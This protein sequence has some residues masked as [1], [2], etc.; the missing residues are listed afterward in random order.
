MPL[1][2]NL[3][4]LGTVLRLARRHLEA[5]RCAWRE[6][7][8]RKPESNIPGGEV[9]F[10][11]AVLE[12]QQAPPS[13]IGRAVLWTIMALFAL[14]AVWACIGK[15]DIVSVARGRIVP[16]GYTKTIQP[17]E[18]GLVTAIHVRNGQRVT[19]GQVLI[20]L[21][22]TISGAD[23][24]RIRQEYDA[25][26]V[27]MARLQALLQ[28][29]A[30]IQPSMDADPAYTALQQ[31]LLKDQMEEYLARIAAAREVVAQRQAAIGAIEADILRL[32]QILPMVTHRAESFRGLYAQGFGSRLEA[33][34]A[35][36]ERIERVQELA[37]SRRRHELEQSAL[38]E[39]RQ[40]LA[41]IG[42]EFRK[43]IQSQLADM[44]NR[45]KALAEE[46]VKATHADRR[47]RLTAPVD[48]TVQQLAV[49]TIGGVVTP[50]QPLMVIVPD[51]DQLEVEAWVENK[52]IGFVAVG[53]AAEIKVDAFP[54]TRY[55]IIDGEL[56][57]LAKDSMLIEEVGYVYTARV[58]MAKAEMQVENGRK[59]RLS[60][61]MDVAV[62]IRTG[63]RRLIEFLLS[64]ILKA[65]RESARER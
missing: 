5:W 54:F 23:R 35:E 43:S 37:A 53:Q 12:M 16:G 11:P 13:P 22:P 26:R 18:S 28:N 64:P 9:E 40:N 56:V 17:L 29:R 59:V 32:E 10:L 55:G 61:G 2:D 34:E 49:H 21:D 36:R 57:T 8:R 31:R 48:G 3:L 20:D 42:S 7:S 24:A 50:A 38:V 25:A 63:Q 6:E 44:E 33:D 62:E 15:I 51:E 30:T 46:L 19:K 47:Q 45:A 41:A 52:D 65:V 27:D 39:A 58:K 1:P 14:G 60:P 4:G